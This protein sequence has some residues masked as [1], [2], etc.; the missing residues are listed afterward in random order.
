M[1]ILRTLA[2]AAAL[3]VLLV[4]APQ[5]TSSSAVSAP[6]A[7]PVSRATGASH[8]P[9]TP[10]AADARRANELVTNLAQTYRHLD[11]VTVTVGET[12]DH[13]QAIA[14]YTQGRI[15][16][17]PAHTA[18]VDEII[19]HEIWHVI[20]WRDNGRIDWGEDLP[21]SNASDYLTR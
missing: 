8:S 2:V 10:S 5:T 16:L 12:P 6:L 4:G 20:D 7:S 19:A 18:T 9:E 13:E 3:S 11:G 1:R 17:S 21:P 15:V 14:Y